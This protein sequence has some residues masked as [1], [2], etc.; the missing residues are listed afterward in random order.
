MEI[1]GGFMVMMSSLGFFLAIIWFITPFIVFATKGKL[2]RSLE[3]LDRIEKRLADME[4]Q[5]A[6]L[7][8]PEKKAIAGPI[9][10]DVPPNHE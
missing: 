10:A 7:K 1:F 3:M 8:Q 5:L 9:E 4:S 2:D 6:A